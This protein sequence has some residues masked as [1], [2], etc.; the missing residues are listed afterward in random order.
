MVCGLL[1]ALIFSFRQ[2][3]GVLLC[4][5]QHGHRFSHKAQSFGPEGQVVYDPYADNG[6]CYR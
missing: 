4:V 2:V 6:L 1:A 3:L 5:A